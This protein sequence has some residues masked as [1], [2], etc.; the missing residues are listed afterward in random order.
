MES[1]ANPVAK[2]DAA[3][4][5]RTAADFS[6]IA[7][8]VTSRTTDLIAIGVVLVGGLSMGRQ[9][10]EWWQAEPP[11]VAMAGAGESANFLSS[12][13]ESPVEL[14]F[15]D[16]PLALRRQTVPGDRDAAI[17]ALVT[18]CRTS[19][20]T[21]HR[22]NLPSGEAADRLLAHTASLTPVAESAGAWQIYRLEDRFSLVLGVRLQHG[23]GGNETGE[24]K[25]LARWGL[26]APFNDTTW[27]LY[28]FQPPNSG[29]TSVAKTPEIPLP[30]E[31]RRL[32]ALRG[33]DGGGLIGF[34]GEGLPQEWMAFFD[35]KLGEQGWSASGGWTSGKGAWSARFES[36]E[37]SR[38][39]QVSIEFSRA[40]SGG[41]MGLI[42]IDP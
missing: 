35:D 11:S 26:A 27:T 42:Q 9:V 4:P 18:A 1:S 29:G 14:E 13:G 8:K 25:R 36:R 23:A 15:G 28:L 12:A 32:L 39:G 24:T 3:G 33:A 21:G 30:P 16:Y 31:G 7:R 2:N 37:K 22:A 38:A 6:T 41:L 20:E 10:I 40:A 17:A 34:S 5:K 19:L